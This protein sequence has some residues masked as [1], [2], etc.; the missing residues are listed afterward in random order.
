MQKDTFDQLVESIL[1][2]CFFDF[3]YVK[4]FKL[5]LLNVKHIFRDDPRA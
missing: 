1:K 4:Y 3:L 2:T 5:N